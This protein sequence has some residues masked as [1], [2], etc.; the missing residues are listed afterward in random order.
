VQETRQR[1]LCQFEAW[2][3]QVLAGEE[4]LQGVAAELI[5]AL[6]SGAAVPPVAGQCDLYSLWSALTSI[7][8]EIR[9]QSRTF[10]Q[11]NETLTQRVL[12]TADHNSG[13]R[14]G[15]RRVRKEE[16]E[17]LLDLRDRLDR[18]RVSVDKAGS[19]AAWSPVRSRLARWLGLDQSL[20]QVQETVAAL[21]KGYTLT[22]DR[23]EEVLRDYHV[24][25]IACEGQPF[26]P[27]RMTAVAIEETSAVP[28]GTVVAVYRA[29]YEW[30]GEVHRSAQVKVAKARREPGILERNRDQ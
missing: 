13:P 2:L 30:D 8:Q 10:K 7:T 11:L 27:H 14:E 18:G 9:L 12:Q 5:A 6:E 16:I 28:E 24:S 3:D 26:D 22:L 1:I 4:P 15:E 25:A 21:G 19:G 17:V 29:G 23:L 20:R